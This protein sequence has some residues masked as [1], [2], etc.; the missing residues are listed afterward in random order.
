MVTL[1]DYRKL[2]ASAEPVEAKLVLLTTSM[3]IFRNKVTAPPALPPLRDAVLPRADT[4]TGKSFDEV[5]RIVDDTLKAVVKL[6]KE[7]AQDEVVAI[8]QEMKALSETTE[9][10]PTD[11]LPLLQ[12]GFEQLKARVSIEPAVVDRVILPILNPLLG[13]TM[14]K[15][16][17]V[18]A[19]MQ[20]SVSGQPPS[21][22]R[23][24]LVNRLREV[25]E[26][27]AAPPGPFPEKLPEI[28]DAVLQI[29]R[30]FEMP[31]PT[32]AFRAAIRPLLEN[33]LR[34]F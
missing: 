33:V 29:R 23:D 25:S 5:K 16:T 28:M 22:V 8:L 32:P 30:G 31:A 34:M 27:V 20:A 15:W 4:A 6:S 11:M 19:E 1:A 26:Y 3:V 18:L 14:T 2:L 7:P 9:M 10:S 17:A 12:M 13:A 21:L 24:D